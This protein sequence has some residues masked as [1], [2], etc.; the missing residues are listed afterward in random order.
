MTS[1][2]LWRLR[3]AGGKAGRARDFLNL[4][5]EEALLVERRLALADTLRLTRKK[6]G[7]SQIEPAGMK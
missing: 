2:S 6:H 7:R 3:I 5:D 4:S 1:E